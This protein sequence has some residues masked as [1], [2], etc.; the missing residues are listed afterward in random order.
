MELN[1]RIPEG[2]IDE[3]WVHH[4]EHIKLVGRS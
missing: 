4:L 1:A 2:P 3:K